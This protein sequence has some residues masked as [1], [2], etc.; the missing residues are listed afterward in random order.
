MSD[1]ASV[2]PHSPVSDSAL[3][4]SL[5]FAKKQL[6]YPYVLFSGLGE[7]QPVGEKLKEL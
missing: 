1:S 7:N 5:L 4:T 3:L 6:S 2:G